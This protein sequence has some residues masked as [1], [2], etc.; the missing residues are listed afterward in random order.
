[1]NENCNNY[2]NEEMEINLIDLMFYLLRRWK[3]MVVL[4]VLGLL[5]GAGIYMLKSP[6]SEEVAEEETQSEVDLEAMKEELEITDSALAN[7]KTANEYQKLYEKQIEYN[8]NSLIMQLNP[9]EMY[10]GTLKYYISA[11]NNTDLI[12]A[13]YQNL[14]L[15]SGIFSEICERTGL[16]C[17][18]EYVREMVWSSLS[19]KN[20]AVINYN[21]LTDEDGGAFQSEVVTYSVIYNNPE[22]CE[23]IL[24]VLQERVARLNQECQETYGEHLQE[25]IYEGVRLSVDTG[26]ITRQKT[27]IDAENAYITNITKIENE[28]TEDELAY[29]N[30][31]YTDDVKEIEIEETEEAGGI[32]VKSLIK[33]LLVGIIL[34]L[35]CWGGYY[36]LRYLFD[37]RVK[38]AE[39]ISSYYGIHLIGRYQDGEK[40]LKGI[41]RLQ[42]QMVNKNAGD[43]SNK[44]Y[45]ASAISLL[46]EKT[47]FMV[48]NTEDEGVAG[49]MKSIQGL[50]QKAECGNLMQ[51]DTDALERAKDKEGVVL[52]VKKGTDTHPEI[53]RELEICRLQKL[54]VV[55]AVVVE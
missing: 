13:C 15:D 31:L 7:M 45:L 32:Q 50:C 54:R 3:S 39:E 23:K 27:N 42:E 43:Y 55:G 48:G 52:F 14:L 6:G 25:Q 24:E 18:E 30:A 44:E 21:E 51:N 46:N 1:M 8:Q 17:G 10:T 11:G 9:T 28:F 40:T 22:T 36:L 41:D 12:S 2:N 53:Q 4:A 35:F 34:G 26:Y 33:W 38:Y 19:G 20:V 37:K 47:L 5:L 16:E 49:L 29:Y